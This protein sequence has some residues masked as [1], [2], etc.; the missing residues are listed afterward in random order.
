MRVR[1]WGDGRVVISLPFVVGS[2]N[3]NPNDVQCKRERT[4]EEREKRKFGDPCLHI[5]QFMMLTRGVRE[6][7]KP[8]QVLH[9]YTSISKMKSHFQRSI[10]MNTKYTKH[11]KKYSYQKFGSTMILVRGLR[12][13]MRSSKERN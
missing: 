7:F 5:I 8:S 10:T 6:L 12:T 13:F 2:I 3:I 11:I 1:C 9:C 4:N